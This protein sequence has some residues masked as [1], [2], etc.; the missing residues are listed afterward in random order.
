MIKLSTNRTS[1]RL[2][3]L[4]E[5]MGKTTAPTPNQ[6]G[7]WVVSEFGPPSVLK[8]QVLESLP[9]PS[10]DDVRV[11]I[12]AAGASGADNLQRVGGY[13]DPRC[14]K[15][16]FTPGYDFVGEIE[17]LGPTVAES[18][19]LAV[20]DRVAS[21]C[22]VGAHATHMLVPAG[23]LLRLEKDDDPV[24]MCALPLN[25]MTAY[26]L[27]KR[28]GVSLPRGSSILI[29]SAASGV[30]T[31]I[32]Q[33]AEAFDM[34]LTM[35]GTC[36]ASKVD[37]V[38]SL[39]VTPIDRRASDVT[40]QVRGLTGGRGVDVA[41]DAVGSKES[42]QISH[43]SAK[44]GT[45]Q[46]VCYGVV[47]L[48]RPDGSG[49]LPVDFDPWKYIQDGKLR[50]G[51]VFAVTHDYYYTQKDL[52]VRDF[53]AVAEKVREGKLRPSICKLFPLSEVI[54]ANELLASGEGVWGKMEFVVDFEL[55]KANIVRV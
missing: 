41:Y 3:R 39:G 38:K 7:R 25:Y 29:G 53:Q 52:F 32:A 34:G 24:R 8:W 30:G 6:P 10:N 9:V 31:A 2:S 1:H 20:G 55:A 11:S 4:N 45:G 26:G 21:M 48:V 46:V 17:E 50:G 42:L 5:N 35:Y 16:G 51:T 47:S 44:E 37:F 12:L 49:M 27:L 28:S 15:P 54:K 23:N 13:P 43:A 19:D 22:T 33:L 36:P 18:L 40:V 14:E